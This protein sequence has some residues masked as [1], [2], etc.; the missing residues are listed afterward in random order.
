ML[1][2]DYNIS[3]TGSNWRVEGDWPGEVMGVTREGVVGGK[4]AL[5][6]PGEVYMVNKDGWL[7]KVDDVAKLVY[8]YENKL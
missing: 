7:V 5:Y 2:V 3:Q 1:W 4:S 6:K 8:T